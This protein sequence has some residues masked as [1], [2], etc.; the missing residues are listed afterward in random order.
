MTDSDGNTHRSTLPIGKMAPHVWESQLAR[1]SD[2]NPAFRELVKAT[3]QPFVSA[4]RESRPAH[5][6]F[7]G[8][9]LL[10]VGDAAGSLRPNAGQAF[11]QAA[12][13]CLLLEKVLKREQGMTIDMWEQRS[14]ESRAIAAAYSRWFGQYYLGG[15]TSIIASYVEYKA[16]LALQS[17][18]LWKAQNLG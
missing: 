8:G 4:I 12:N 15:W 16:R 3:K 2:L 14:M 1:A 17:F 7:F 13:Q 10:L 5:L 11:N 9:H 18:R 6:S